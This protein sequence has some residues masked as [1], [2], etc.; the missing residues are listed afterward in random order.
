MGGWAIG[1]L[2]L[3]PGVLYYI[4]IFLVPTIALLRQGVVDQSGRLSAEWYGAFVH[5]AFYVGIFLRT[6]KLSLIA[7]GIAFVLG[8]PCATFL[9]QR[10]R[11]K[12]LM[13]LAV[14]APLLVSS[15]VRSYGWIVILGPNGFLD[16][17][18]GL[19]G[20]HHVDLLFSETAVTVA[21]AQ[22]FLP[23]MVLPIAGSLLQIDESLLSAA[24]NLG[25]GTVM[26]FWRVVLPLSLPGVGAGC[27]ITFSLCASSFVTPSLL[28]GAKVPVM[29]YLVYEQGLLQLN[30]PFAAAVATILL[31]STVIL[32]VGYTFALP[33]RSTDRAL[34]Q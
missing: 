22:V 29:A 8:Y 25:A 12:S 19:L 28:G 7:T 4:V 3:I 30:W 11:G 13:I 10:R 21:L 14:L 17:I 24:S 2:L 31:A 26:V 16:R 27:V 1:V 6:L 15:V 20:G 33:G 5:N 23:F 32:S 9:A 34:A 18:G